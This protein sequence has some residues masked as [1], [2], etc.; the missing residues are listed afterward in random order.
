[1]TTACISLPGKLFFVLGGIG[2]F[3]II[4]RFPMA[5]WFKVCALFYMVVLAMVI[6]T[7][8]GTPIHGSTRWLKIGIPIQPSEFFKPLLVVQASIVFGRWYRL[9]L[10][11][12]GIWIA[13]FA[14]GLGPFCSSR[15]WGQRPS[16]QGRCC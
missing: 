5:T 3:A 9:P 12:R 4:V 14:L 10:Y 16:V 6:A 15:I 1:M 13:L 11:Y 7:H 8:F 2:C